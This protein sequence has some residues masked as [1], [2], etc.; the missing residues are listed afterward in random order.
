V[1]LV[2]LLA[3][4]IPLGLTACG[5]STPTATTTK[6]TKLPSIPTDANS[7]PTV[8]VESYL[9][10]LSH[11]DVDVAKKLLY[12]K[13]RKA[14]MDATG[15]GFADL[16][17]L[18]D[19]KVLAT[20]TGAQYEPVVSGISF[21]KYHEFAQV[22]VSYTATFSSTKQPSGPQKR[23]VTVGE[24]SSSHWIILAIKAS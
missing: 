8:T 23:L 2:P 5:S 21:S 12:P 1:F 16:T 9:S 4:V 17:N 13:T 19:I 18:Q 20:A 14:I 22:T 11:H 24:N 6:H 7:T 3:I 10:A 15:S